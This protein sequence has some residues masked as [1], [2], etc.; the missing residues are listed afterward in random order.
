MIGIIGGGISGLAVA[1]HLER[2]GLPF[3]L[4]EANDEAGGVMR[5]RAV[6]GLP[7]DV[8]PQ[9]TRM[10][11]EV[12]EL[13][14]AAGLV[15][16]LLV[17]P[18][19]VPLYVYRD[20]RLR[21][22]PF[23]MGAAVT[24]DL[25]GWFAKLRVLGEPFTAGPRPEETVERFFIRKF[26]P[27]A[28]RSM[29]GPLYGGLYASDPSQMFVRHGLS[30]TL[31]HFGV[32]GSLL[33]T[34]LRR[35]N[36]ARRQIP[37][38]SFTGGMQM[39]PE[40]LRRRLGD[41]VRAGSRVTAIRRL[42]DPRSRPG[43]EAG[44]GGGGARGREGPAR[45]R[46]EVD[47]SEPV[48]VERVV[49][50]IPAP[51]AAPLL[52]PVSTGASERVGS[53]RYNRLAVVHMMADETPGGVPLVGFGYQV[54]FGEP[55]ETRG[56]TWNGPIFGRDRMCA[57]YLGGMKNPELP[58][59]DDDRIAELARSEFRRA[60]GHDA[61]VLLVSRTWIPAWDGTWD[62]LDGLE[63]PE[64]I[65]VCANWNARP[66]IPGRAAMAKRL[67]ERIAAE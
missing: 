34:L 29:I 66:G 9:R 46:L 26:G 27:Q 59:W 43:G 51:D 28:Y 48:D 36:A 60:T 18:E 12:R 13:V 5:T 15:D 3:V 22:V 2:K 25:L 10:T 4:L 54:A 31:D 32:K 63:M 30:M 67:V 35:G 58:G 52:E 38:V 44:P 42:E 7:L 65:D 47:G 49:I 40:A 50:C 37:T 24:T 20:G 53:L 8:G 11:R 33:L 41:R 14:E 17:A 61:R 64:G 19:D 55:L 56:C 21:E 23:S 6:D 57:A 45:Y 16:E 62:A 39:L 1:W